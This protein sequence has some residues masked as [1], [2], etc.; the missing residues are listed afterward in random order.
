MGHGIACIL[1]FELI[2]AM[3]NRNAWV[4]YLSDGLPMPALGT[5]GKSM[6]PENY[7]VHPR[8]RT[9]Y[10]PKLV[11]PVELHWVLKQGHFRR[12]RFE[13]FFVFLQQTCATHSTTPRKLPFLGKHHTIVIYPL[14]F[15]Q[16]FS[17]LHLYFPHFQDEH[18][19]MGLV[20]VA[21]C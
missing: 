18:L 8:G 5:T 11:L 3:S 21:V 9:Q 17:S 14:L 6:A 15:E 13:F 16:H 1:V 4:Q 20:H 2:A 10:A 19:L 7:A 12:K